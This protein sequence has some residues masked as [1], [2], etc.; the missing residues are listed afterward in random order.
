M[1]IFDCDG[2]LVDSEYVFAQSDMNFL[3]EIGI[4]TTAEDL[5]CRYS[6]MSYDN[7]VKDMFARFGPVFT[8]ELAQEMRLRARKVLSDGV[9]MIAGI[10][11]VITAL[12]GSICVASNSDHD[13]LK[14]VLGQHNIYQ[15]FDPHLFS[16]RDVERPKPY[17]DLHLHAAQKMGVAPELC[18]VVE[19]SVTGILAAKAAGMVAIGFIAAKHASII[20]SNILYEAGADRVVHT[21]KE[22]QNLLL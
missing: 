10:D 17:P 5:I 11:D 9:P 18:I 21:S 19:D 3:T 16:A 7:M 2:V 13:H 4:T 8:P 6:G 12:P 14:N 20:G 1:I 22:L 15:L